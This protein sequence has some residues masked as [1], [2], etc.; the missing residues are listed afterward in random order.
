[1]TARATEQSHPL[2]STGHRV[3]TVIPVHRPTL[4]TDERLRVLK[5][6]RN[7]APGSAFFVGPVRLTSNMRGDVFDCAPFAAF[8]DEHFDSL[9]AY[10]RWV[11]RPD[12][13]VRFSEFDFVLICQTDAIL[14]R[15]LPI[16]EEWEFDYLGAP[17]TP[18]WALRWDPFKRQLRGS[19][20]SFLRRELHV[21]NGGLS[22]RRPSVFASRLRFPRFRKTPNEDVAISYFH[23]RL[24]IR[25]APRET[26]QRFFMETEASAWTPDLPVPDVYGFHG[27]NLINPALETQVLR[28]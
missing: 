6:L 12:L 15:P 14:V 23:K 22:L 5:T 13:Y 26:A 18:P 17:W 1:M 11:L 7:V 9:E 3:A 21:G 2:V 28:P 8:P 4:T 24:G 19:V 16:T 25:I 20:P 10:N 27:L